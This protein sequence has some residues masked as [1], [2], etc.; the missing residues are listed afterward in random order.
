M[1][2]DKTIDDL[3]M[4]GERYTAIETSQRYGNLSF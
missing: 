3:G 2:H 4:S 1:Q